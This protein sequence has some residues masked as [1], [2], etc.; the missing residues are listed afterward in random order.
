MK[1]QHKI[2]MAVCLLLLPYMSVAQEGV[3]A[4]LPA[5]FPM[6]APVQESTKIFEGVALYPPKASLEE[7]AVI[8]AAKSDAMNMAC[9]KE[10]QLAV[11]YVKK[12]VEKGVEGQEIAR[13]EQIGISTLEERVKMIVD[14]KASCKDSNFLLERFR[15]M[16]ELRAVSYRLQGVDPESVPSSADFSEIEKLMPKNGQE[17]K[18]EA[19]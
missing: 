18:G 5:D 14:A 19:Q 4:D 7:Q 10:T 2:V 9:G 11:A 3:P 8:L 6:D 13:L 12:F 1:I 15:V 16:R 17:L